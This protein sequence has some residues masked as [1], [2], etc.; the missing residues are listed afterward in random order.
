MSHVLG[1]LRGNNPLVTKVAINAN[2]DHLLDAVITEALEQNHHIV[3]VL[4]F[5][6]HGNGA[7]ASR[8]SWPL[9]FRHLESRVD[10]S[11]L[12]FSTVASFKKLMQSTWTLRELRVHFGGRHRSKQILMEIIKSNFS[13]RVVAEPDD[14]TFHAPPIFNDQDRRLLQF[15]ADRNERTAQWILF[16]SICGPMF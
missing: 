10:F 16:P 4:I 15:Y 6:Q 5:C 2:D 1:I 8:S 3:T 9:L 12:S 13:I 14:R 11:I 7:S